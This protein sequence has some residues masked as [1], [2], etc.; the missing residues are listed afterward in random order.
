MTKSLTY[1]LGS[2][3]VALAVVGCDCKNAPTKETPTNATTMT[4]KAPFQKKYTNKDFYDAEGNFKQ[5]VAKKA[6][7]EMFEYY[8][9]PFTPLM[10][11]DI[12]FVDF[13]LGDFEN[14]GMGGIFW[15]NDK[16]H[17]YFAHEIY[18]LPGQMIP[19]HKHVATDQ[20]AKFESWMV[21]KGD[22]YNFSEVGDPTPGAPA[23][24]ASQAASTISKNAV[25]QNPGEIIHLKKEGTW[26]FL[27]AGDQGAIVS[28][29]A[30]Y[31]DGNGL[32]FSNT[33][34]KM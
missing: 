4:K 18:L 5:D 23:V 11:K 25:K 16:D 17:G 27:Y 14:C 31:H 24:P 22:C 21:A 9:V 33:K 15:V 26:H 7:L 12:W 10:E 30:N 1:L 34:A 6:F 8:D 19:E 32:K 3:T 2:L 28:E 20:P 13:G 29:Y